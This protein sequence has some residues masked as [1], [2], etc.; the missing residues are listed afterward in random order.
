ME[1]CSPA[2]KTRQGGHYV[3]LNR[4]GC[5]LT[6]DAEVGMAGDTPFRDKCIMARA[7]TQSSQI[8][9]KEH[10][11]QLNECGLWGVVVNDSGINLECCRRGGRRHAQKCYALTRHSP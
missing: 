10:C 7:A 1:R 4:C 9:E 6:H 3:Y 2:T 11:M 8:Q 5:A